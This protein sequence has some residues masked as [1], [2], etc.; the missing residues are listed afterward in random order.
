M[1]TVLIFLL[2]ALTFCL[3]AA[4]LAALAVGIGFLLTVCVPTLQLGH[5]IIA[6]AVVAAAAVYFFRIFMKAVN[7]HTDDDDTVP[8]TPPVVVLPRDF[9]PRRPRRPKPRGKGK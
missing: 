3:I 4:F 8:D 1:G 2:M 9:I 7:N 6:G 5:A